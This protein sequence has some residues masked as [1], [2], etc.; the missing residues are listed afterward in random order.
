[1]PNYDVLKNMILDL[2]WRSGL[3][4]LRKKIAMKL[5]SIGEKYVATDND[6]FGNLHKTC[7]QGISI[8]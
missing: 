6:L 5:T 3:P 2:L 4:P 1:M 8:A 7:H